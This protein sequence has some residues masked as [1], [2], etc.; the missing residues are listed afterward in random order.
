M[1]RTG[2]FGF[3]VLGLHRL[4]GSLVEGIDVLLESDGLYVVPVQRLEVVVT[5]GA[6][7]DEFLA[8]GGR[9]QY[10]LA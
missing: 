3:A 4:S 8:R 7:L 2:R 6:E 1:V 10:L 9:G 5:L